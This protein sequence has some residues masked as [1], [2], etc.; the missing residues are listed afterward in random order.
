MTKKILIAEDETDLRNLVKIYLEIYDVDVIEAEDGEVAIKIAKE[1]KP[2]LILC[3]NNMPGLTGYEVLQKLKFLPETKNIPVIMVTGK[4]F[5]QEMQQ[6]IKLD[7]AD[8]IQKPYEEEK[9]VAAIT[10]VLGPLQKKVVPTE[11]PV[12]VSTTETL[13]SAETV[14]STEPVPSME[15]QEQ[16]RTESQIQ[17]PVETQV[18]SEITAVQQTQKEVSSAEEQQQVEISLP[19]EFVVLSGTE[20]EKT[21][22]SPIEEQ[23]QQPVSVEKEQVVPQKEEKVEQVVLPPE[24]E[25]IVKQSVELPEVSKEKIVE[26][27]IVKTSVE[28]FCKQFFAAESKL[29][30]SF[31]KK[32]TKPILLISV[33]DETLLTA[34]LGSK[35]DKIISVFSLPVIIVSKELFDKNNKKISSYI[36]KI[37]EQELELENF[38]RR[39]V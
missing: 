10:K 36:E 11:E 9:L 8:F 6:I 33:S 28:N 3:D 4:K 17:P 19:P 14:L 12:T 27:Y 13:S 25:E 26:I 37:S 32:Y 16:L 31:D 29:T 24:I 23:V 34:E 5:D 35:I 21:I 22:I 20:K 1:Q 18:P 38:V 39:L 15:V 30:I 2:D 7:A